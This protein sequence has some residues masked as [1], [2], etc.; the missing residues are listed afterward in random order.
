MKLVRDNG[1]TIVLV[2]ASL[3]TIGGMFA[4]GWVVQESPHHKRGTDD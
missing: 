3:L 1:L 4:T 2:L